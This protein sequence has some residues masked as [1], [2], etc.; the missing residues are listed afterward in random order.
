MLNQEQSTELIERLPYI[1]TFQAPNDRILE[2][3]FEEA[4]LQNDPVGWIRVIKTCY[5]RKNDNSR[6][7]KF[8][9]ERELQLEQKAKNLF[10]TALSEALLISLEDVEHYIQKHLTEAEW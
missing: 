4:V 10:H 5:I 9:T 1:R 3:F 2:D 8:L 7:K 6:K